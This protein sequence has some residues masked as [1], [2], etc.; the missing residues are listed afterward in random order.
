MYINLALIHVHKLVNYIGRMARISIEFPGNPKVLRA[1][2]FLG[3]P[4]AILD[5]LRKPLYIQCTGKCLYIVCGLY[6]HVTC[7]QQ[8]ERTVSESERSLDGVALP[9]TP[10]PWVD[11]RGR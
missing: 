3:I 7:M 1:T 2:L 11:L 10:F 5:N 8:A 6:M 4:I 9:R